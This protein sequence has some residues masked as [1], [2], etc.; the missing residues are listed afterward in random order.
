M[1]SD[2]GEVGE[3]S[4]TLKPRGLVDLPDRLAVVSDRWENLRGSYT[5]TLTIHETK[6]LTYSVINKKTASQENKSSNI[7]TLLS[8]SSSFI[9]DNQQIDVQFDKFIKERPN[10]RYEDWITE[11]NPQNAEEDMLG[12]GQTIIDSK[13]YESDNQY[14]LYWNSHVDSSR[15]AVQAA[16]ANHH[17][18]CENDASDQGCFQDLLFSGDEGDHSP[19]CSISERR[20]SEQVAP[21]EDLIKFD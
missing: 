13:F 20:G 1:R 14:L 15:L 16:T 9:M 8:S 12:L 17:D 10:P 6:I 11:L 2:G 19:P 21:G 3:L 7:I 18:V 5:V 4:L